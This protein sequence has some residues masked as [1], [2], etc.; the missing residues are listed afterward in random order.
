MSDNVG[1][2]GKR[3]SAR[4]SLEQFQSFLLV[5]LQLRAEISVRRD[6]LSAFMSG[7]INDSVRVSEW[8]AKKYVPSFT[9]QVSSVISFSAYQYNFRNENS[10][11]RFSQP[12]GKKGSIHTFISCCIDIPRRKVL[13]T[14]SRVT[15]TPFISL[16][17]SIMKMLSHL[18]N[19]NHLFQELK[20]WRHCCGT[21]LGILYQSF[22]LSLA[23]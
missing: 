2:W 10:I 16:L 20:P 12:M 3:C 13:E 11:C 6:E 22:I 15:S 8:P 18:S 5:L 17:T 1:Y 23:K 21:A 9:T 19:K 4:R 14:P 7:C